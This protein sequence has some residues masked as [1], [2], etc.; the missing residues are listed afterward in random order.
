MKRL[1]TR[2]GFQQGQMIKILVQAHRFLPTI[3][4]D[5][6]LEVAMSV[7]Q[8]HRAEV[9]I[10]VAGRLAMIAGKNTETAGIVRHGFVKPEFRRKIGDTWR[11]RSKFSI[12]VASRH[13]RLEFLV[14]GLHFTDVVV[15][16]CE[17]DQTGLARELQ[18]PD[19]VVV[20][21]VPELSIQMPKEPSSIGLPG[22]P[23]IVSKFTERFQI[24][25]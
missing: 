3:F 6:L 15:I 10:E 11:A 14:H 19:W 13:V 25:R 21:S 22:P 7:K 23:Q 8:R 24:L 9:Q 5:L 12:S 2:L 4:V 16:G 18:H 1:I 17:F 20:R